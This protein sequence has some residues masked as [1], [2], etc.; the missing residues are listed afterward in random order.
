M[1]PPCPL[2]HAASYAQTRSAR[3]VPA[4]RFA[5][6]TAPDSVT[7]TVSSDPAAPP[8]IPSATSRPPHRRHGVPRPHFH[9]LARTHQRPRHRRPHLPRQK[10][11][12]VTDPVR[13]RLLA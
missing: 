1:G 7:T 2:I 9:L 13:L 10:L 5:T 3:P 11:H 6:S 4:S 8:R 12:R